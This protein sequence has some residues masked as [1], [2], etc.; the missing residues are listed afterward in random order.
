MKIAIIDSDK[1]YLPE[2]S[3]YLEFF[4]CNGVEIERIS[5]KQSHLVQMKE[6][7]FI[8]IFPGRDT[9]KG[10][11][12]L[13]I[14]EYNSLSVGKYS[15][16]KN[17]V[18]KW[19][20]PKPT[21]RIFLNEDIRDEFNFKDNVPSLIRDMG[22]SEN[23]FNLEDCTKEYDFVYMGTMGKARELDKILNS[24]TLENK[25]Y[26]LLMIGEPDSELY[27][28]YKIYDNIYFIGSIPYEDVPKFAQKAKYGLN[29]IPDIT[30]Y[31]VQ[32]STKLLEYCALGLKIVTTDYQW[33]NEFE[34][35]HQAKF[36][37]YD[38]SNGQINFSDIEKYEFK[39][40]NVNEYRWKN[41]LQKS[42]ILDFLH[43]LKD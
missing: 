31:N 25:K 21:L 6:Y 2:I 34:F 10:T 7:D 9:F 40:P 12:A 33:V 36:Y 1:A 24:F 19:M 29:H 15:T 20:N 26:T 22:I 5:M 18:K 27:E 28:K 8:W 13:K 42:G 4:N 17:I 35:K 23:F 41:V 37:K 39:T 38:F 30:P 3:A 14:H 43:E 32:T 11:S 16:L